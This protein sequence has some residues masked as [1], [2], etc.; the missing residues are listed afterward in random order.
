M[1]SLQTWPRRAGPSCQG[2]YQTRVGLRSQVV[3]FEGQSERYSR[4]WR[5]LVFY[6]STQETIGLSWVGSRRGGGEP[7]VLVPSL[8]EVVRA[9]GSVEGEWREE[10]FSFPSLG[11]TALNRGDWSGLALASMAARL[12]RL[13]QEKPPGDTATANWGTSV[14]VSRVGWAGQD[15]R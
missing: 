12:E 3:A 11:Q 8:K 5:S 2:L 4:T 13:K 15:K 1:R 6:S 10:L 7:S 9:P 14:T